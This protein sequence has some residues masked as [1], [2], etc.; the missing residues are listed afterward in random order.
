MNNT[1]KIK[2]RPKSSILGKYKDLPYKIE[3][4]LAEF[5]DNSTDSYFKHKEI[6][7]SIGQTSCKV[8][9][10]IQP[11]KIIIKDNAYGMNETDFK[12]ALVLDS[13]PRDKSGRSE[14]G[15]GLKTAATWLGSYWSVQTT[16]YGSC[17]EFFAQM[18]V[19]EIEKEAPEEID[20]KVSNCD[21]NEHYT[22]ITIKNLRKDIKANAIEKANVSLSSMY[23]N[24]IRNKELILIVNKIKLAYEIPELW[25]DSKTNEEY[26]KNFSVEFPFGKQKYS[27]YGWIGIRKKGSTQN[28]GLS[29]VRKGRALRINYKPK[30]LFGGPNSYSQ[31]RLIGEINLDDWDV[32]HLKNDI[33]WEG[34]LEEQLLEEIKKETK[35]IL[36]L[37]EELRAKKDYESSDAK[38]KMA[39]NNQNSFK[40]LKDTDTTESNKDSQ[41]DALQ[42]EID[43]TSEKQLKNEYIIENPI[44]PIIEIPFK[45]KKYSFEIIYDKKISDDWITIETTNEVDKYRLILN[46]EFDY[47]KTYNDERKKVEF[48]QKIAITIAMA[49]IL[50]KE[51]GN[52]D[53]YRVLDALNIIVRKTR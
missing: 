47:F 48:L 10:D 13:P 36:K 16:E 34:G 26:K 33:Q 22:I 43:L 31:Q 14:K 41:I 35:D 44:N 4:S 49:L 46:I 20:A 21:A 30:I 39:K 11:D 8:E 19:D 2:I 17:K 23:S 18:N 24:D 28:E 53:Y 1:I 38:A 51:N 25:R 5:I 37:A 7:N 40:N 52:H 50:S 6:L 45:N 32:T 12:R 29:I 15:M 9:I 42:K 3:E 27:A